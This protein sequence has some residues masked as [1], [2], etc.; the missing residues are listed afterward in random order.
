M[1]ARDMMSSSC[2][3]G[4]LRMLPSLRA[5][6]GDTTSRGAPRLQRRLA[7]L[8]STCS[9]RPRRR[10]SSVREASSCASWIA[11]GDVTGVL[12]CLGVCAAVGANAERTRIGRALSGPVVAMGL[13][14]ALGTA[15]VLPD[16]SAHSYAPLMDALVRVGTPLLLL[17]SNV[18]VILRQGGAALPAFAVGAVGTIVGG[19]TGA[20]VAGPGLVAALGAEDAAKLAS[21]L[22]AKNVG[23]GVNFV[24]VATTTGMGT[25][26][27]Q[28]GYAAD[29]VV[30]ILYFL[31][32]F[33]IGNRVNTAAAAA[34]AAAKAPDAGG[35]VVPDAAPTP[36]LPSTAAG[37]VAGAA[38][39]P[40][41]ATCLGG[42][43]LL[44]AV[45]GRVAPDGYLPLETAAVVALA[46]L[47]PGVTTPLAAPGAALG[48]ALLYLFFA[49]AGACGGG[50]AA[51]GLLS[52]SPAVL[53]FSA[54]LAA[55]HLLV[56]YVVGRKL[57]GLDARVLL[58]A[59]NANV[60]GPA[61][62]ASMAASLEWPALVVPGIL[63]G[64]LGL[65]LAT[66]LGLALGPTLLAALASN[67][68]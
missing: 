50:V 21:A 60:G 38:G 11:A 6:R 58:V 59:S 8:W 15:G 13:A 9:S 27:F 47:L 43:L 17:E 1:L 49:A 55:V 63:V 32:V 5:P 48:G 45:C 57:L 18:G 26:A 4:E 33:A 16:P 61:T 14:L 37:A 24:A 30:G 28:L 12:G 39:A 44:S 7:G 22:V 10:R 29:N 64:T 3:A 67:P 35:D 66:F 19:L 54:T 53:L 52:R 40:A 2:Y 56:V 36:P 62:A 42:A 65:A 68:A 31:T 46:T 20:L 34:A 41:L 23:S 25:D 51:G